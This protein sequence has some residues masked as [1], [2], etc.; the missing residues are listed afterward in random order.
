MLAACICNIPTNALQLTDSDQLLD[1]AQTL[2]RCVT[3]HWRTLKRKM[4]CRGFCECP[5]ICAPLSRRLCHQP[6]QS[7]EATDK[8]LLSSTHPT[9]MLWYVLLSWRESNHVIRIFHQAPKVVF[10]SPLT[11]ILRPGIQG[12]S[13][14]M[15]NPNDLKKR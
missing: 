3:L 10:E 9:N 7:I 8:K 13:R 11:L 6:T 1:P 14:T 15:E 12:L 4:D 2:N 5:C